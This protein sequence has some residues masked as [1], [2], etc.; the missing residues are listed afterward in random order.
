MLNF[1]SSKEPPFHRPTSMPSGMFVG[2]DMVH[3]FLASIAVVQMKV[4]IASEENGFK[5]P[6]PLGV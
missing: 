1:H 5:L 2:D 6:R 3:V 4:L